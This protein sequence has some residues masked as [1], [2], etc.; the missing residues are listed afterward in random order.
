MNNNMNR[1]EYLNKLTGELNKRLFKQHGYSLPLDTIKVSCGFPCRKALS[2]KNRTIGQCFPTESNGYNEIFIHPQLEDITEIGGVL[3]HELI[4]A[5]DDCKNGHKKPFKD[6]AIKVGLTGKMTAT[7]P[8]EELKDL[9]K[10]IEEGLG[11]YPHKSLE[12]ST[13][14][15]QTTRMLKLVCPTSH[16]EQKKDQYILRASNTT[17]ELSGFPVCPCGLQMQQE[18]TE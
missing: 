14:N 2:N 17:I 13:K 11:K 7:E 1:E 9:L 12:P 18:E 6:I 4:H 8:T 5:Y 16:P 3:V 15:K 10:D